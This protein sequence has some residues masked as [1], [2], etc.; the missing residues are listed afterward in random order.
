MIIGRMTLDAAPLS[1]KSANVSLGQSS[2]LFNCGA[3]TRTDPPVGKLVLRS[4]VLAS[5]VQ[6][7]H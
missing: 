4:S 1:S 6:K 3:D 7:A 2:S 5:I